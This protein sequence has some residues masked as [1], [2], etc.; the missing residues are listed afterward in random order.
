MESHADAGAIGVKM[1]D[2]KGNFLPESKRALPTPEVAFYKMFGLSALFPHSERFG[3]Y[4]LSY[5]SEN[6]NNPVDIL[7]GAFM[8]FR[9]K[10]LDESWVFR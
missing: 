1:I 7:S 10:V 5:L 6:K 2:G 9:K 4:H 3:R 8:F